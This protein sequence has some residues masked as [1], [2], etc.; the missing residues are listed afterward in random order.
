[1]EIVN[2][3]QKKHPRNI[4]ACNCAVSIIPNAYLSSNMIETQKAFSVSRDADELMV[5]GT[6]ES[7]MASCVTKCNFDTYL[8]PMQYF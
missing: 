5:T 6:F 8:T 7:E 3:V 1:M 4:T 2:T